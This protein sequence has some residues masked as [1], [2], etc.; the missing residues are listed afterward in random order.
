VI[1][2]VDTAADTQPLTLKIFFGTANGYTLAVQT[3]SALSPLRANGR[4]GYMDGNEFDTATIDA[5]VLTLSEFQLR[6]NTSAKYR[7]QNGHFEMIGYNSVQSDG[8]GTDYDIDY[9]LTTGHL[10]YTETNYE[11]DAVIK[12]RDL[13]INQPKR[14]KLEEHV[15]GDTEVQQGD[16]D[17]M[18]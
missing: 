10:I 16:V 4:N 13:K 6:C 3:D 12:K 15:P 7:Y 17:I 5:G 1:V 14:P 18:L 9:N 2:T 11:T 8:H